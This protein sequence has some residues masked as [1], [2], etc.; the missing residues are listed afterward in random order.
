[1]E[2][3]FYIFLIGLFLNP[4]INLFI[5]RGTTISN[6]EKEEMRLPFRIIGFILMLITSIVMVCNF[7][8]GEWT[9]P[10]KIIF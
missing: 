1:M 10:F 7:S 2:I 5:L 9:I 3:T 6:K 8:S 4:I